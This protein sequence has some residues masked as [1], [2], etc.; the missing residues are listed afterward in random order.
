MMSLFNRLFGRG[1]D[2]LERAHTTSGFLVCSS[3][4]ERMRLYELAA[5]R[6]DEEQ[7][8]LFIE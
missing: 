4:E 6:A 5:Q 1:T 7:R 2:T 8:A 3:K